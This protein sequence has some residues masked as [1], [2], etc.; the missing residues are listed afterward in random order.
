MKN[1]EISL[2][3]CTHNRKE[4]LIESIKSLKKIKKPEFELMVIDSSD[5][6]LTVN[7]K[8]GIDTYIYDKAKKPLSDKRNIAIK[9]CKS[10]IIVF[11]DDDCIATKS[12]L[13]G[14]TNPF[15]D[16]NVMCVTGKTVPFK[17]Y[18]K[19]DYE[20]IFSFDNLGKNKKIMKKHLGLQNLWRFGHGNNMAFRALVFN[21]VGLFDER[22][23]VG[24]EGKAGEDVDIFYKIYKKGYKI[25]FNPN[26][27]ILHKHIAKQDLTKWAQNNTYASHLV[28][29][30]HHDM[31]TLTIFFLGIFKLAGESIIAFVT[32]DMLK[33]KI[34]FYSLLGWLGI[35]CKK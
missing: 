28:L 3:I 34:K 19:S 20:K 2:V 12:W 31:N 7:E 30:K 16:P 14:L 4:H 18:E 1:K 24:T 15:K 13:Y 9:V 26:A 10:E 29:L 35:K 23:G 33:A 21:K 32:G 27:V 5:K 25:V 11:T 17:S 22:L 8:K 6:K